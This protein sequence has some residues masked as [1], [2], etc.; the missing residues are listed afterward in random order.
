MLSCAVLHHRGLPWCLAWKGLSSS[1]AENTPTFSFVS[2]TAPLTYPDWDTR[3]HI[4]YCPGYQVGLGLSGGAPSDKGGD[5]GAFL[6]RAGLGNSPGSKVDAQKLVDRAQSL[7]AQSWPGLCATTTP[8]PL[9]PDLTVPVCAVDSQSNRSR[10][11]HEGSDRPSLARVHNWNGQQSELSCVQQ[12]EE[13]G[14][15]VNTARRR[16]PGSQLARLGASSRVG[17]RRIRTVA[18]L[19]ELTA[20]PWSSDERV[21]GFANGVHA[22]FAN[23]PILSHLSERLCGLCLAKLRSGTLRTYYIAS[24]DLGTSQVAF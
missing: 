18:M 21:T 14:R 5:E 15:T 9:G 11:A 20:D 16:S 23:A 6:L 7:A 2:C 13:P 1:T 17:V 24:R 8:L 10:M 3:E 4:T 12:G 22:C 19:S